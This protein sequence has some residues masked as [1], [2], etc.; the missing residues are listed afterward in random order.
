MY[1]VAY[2]IEPKAIPKLSVDMFNKNNPLGLGA[3][4]KE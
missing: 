2:G 3:N 4:W 1:R